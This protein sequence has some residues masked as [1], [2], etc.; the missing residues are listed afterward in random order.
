MRPAVALPVPAGQHSVAGAPG[1]TLPDASAFIVRP[2]VL[3]DIPSVLSLVNRL[4][5]QQLMLPRSPAS[6]SP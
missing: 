5:Q 3:A 1:S 2:A 4:A 6:V